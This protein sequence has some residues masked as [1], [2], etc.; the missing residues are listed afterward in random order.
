MKQ[1][2]K[3]FICSFVILVLSVFILVVYCAKIMKEVFLGLGRQG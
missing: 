3:N 1:L 2:I